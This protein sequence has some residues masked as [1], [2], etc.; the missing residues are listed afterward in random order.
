M[1]LKRIVR[2]T[3]EFTTVN[4][5]QDAL[6]PP[7]V[8][9]RFHKRDRRAS[10]ARPGGHNPQDAAAMFSK[11]FMG[12]SNCLVLVETLDDGFV[13]LNVL[14]WDRLIPLESPSL[15]VALREEARKQ[16]RV[17]VRVPK[18]DLCTVCQEDE[19]K[20]TVPLLDRFGVASRLFLPDDC[21][22]RGALRFNHGKRAAIHAVEE[23]VREAVGRFARRADLV[24]DFE[25]RST[26]LP[27]RALQLLVDVRG[28]GFG[29][30]DPHAA[31]LVAALSSA[32]PTN[33]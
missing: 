23:V 22:S 4:Q 21:V 5:E 7:S 17:V 2:L 1:L 12:A 25:V 26:D 33:Q 27:T 14:E 30:A 28:S 19:R 3:S 16:A 31:T 8:E 9:Q 20:P 29:L 32:K 6:S 18:P 13:D 11:R 15:Q 10:L 24:L